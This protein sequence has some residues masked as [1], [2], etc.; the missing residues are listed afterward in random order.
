M[1]ACAA[2][3]PVAHGPGVEIALHVNTSEAGAVG[4]RCTDGEQMMHGKLLTVFLLCGCGEA[5]TPV[6]FSADDAVDDGVDSGGS[7]SSDAGGA[8]SSAGAPGA[9]GRSSGGRA[10]GTSAAGETGV[11]GTETGGE[12]GAGG[13][14]TGDGGEPIE[15]LT[16]LSGVGT[17]DFQISFTLTTTET[18][19]TLALVSQ[20]GDCLCVGP[21]SY[22]PVPSTFWDV[23]LQAGA[24]VA[25]T[26]AD[27]AGSYVSIRSDSLVADGRPHHITVGR[28]NGAFWQEIDGI[29]AGNSVS[30]PHSFE[31]FPAL[32]VGAD[33]CETAASATTPLAD[34]GTLAELCLS[35]L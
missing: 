8:G 12:T 9:G 28:T 27:S 22:C 31:V 29:R 24:I 4:P 16:D 19:L 1:G 15:C 2:A 32:S 7:G 33:K 17:G 20:R 25:I 10:G 35:T 30:N 6:G 5:F 18:V 34:H 13:A 21:G 3:L 11:G 14:S 23:V 26:A